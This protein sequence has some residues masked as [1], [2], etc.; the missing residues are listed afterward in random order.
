MKLYI[1]KDTFYSVEY[2]D[3]TWSSV[4]KWLLDK[5][6]LNRIRHSVRMP[7]KV[8]TFLFGKV[9]YYSY[10]CIKQ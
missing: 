2:G 9:K 4:F 1:H 3:Q 5:K 8:I 10:I 7:A 6:D